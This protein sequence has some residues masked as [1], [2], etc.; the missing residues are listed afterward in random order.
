MMMLSWV[1]SKNRRKRSASSAKVSSMDSRVSRSPAT[2]SSPDAGVSK[3]CVGLEAQVGFTL[4]S[5]L[6]TPTL[7]D[8]HAR[9]KRRMSSLLFFAPEPAERIGEDGA[10]VFPVVAAVAVLELVIVLGELQ[11]ERHLLIGQGPVA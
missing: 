8:A 2:R 6:A 5:R 4:A 7:M 9:R 1:A 3:G 11:R 10:A